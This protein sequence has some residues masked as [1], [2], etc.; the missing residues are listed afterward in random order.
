MMEMAK[1]PKVSTR[2]A[3][4]GTR[5]L[6]RTAP[7]QR[8]SEPILPIAYISRVDAVASA[9]E[10]PAMLLTRA[11]KTSSAPANPHTLCASACQ[12]F[13]EAKYPAIFVG[14]QAMTPA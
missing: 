3:L 10:F 2:I 11:R 14:P 9:V 7:N 4:S 6:L 12:A 13:D 1:L 5:R 8:G